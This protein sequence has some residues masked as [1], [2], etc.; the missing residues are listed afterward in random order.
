MTLEWTS[1]DVPLGAGLDT[2]TNEKLL[3]PP[4]CADLVNAVFPATGISG[5]ETRKGYDR[6]RTET[7]LTGIDALATLENELLVV[8]N[9]K[10]YS[11]SELENNIDLVE[12]GDLLAVAVDEETL[13]TQAVNQTLGQII[14]HGGLQVHAWY[15]SGTST[16]QYTVADAVTGTRIVSDSSIANSNYP[17][18]A[19]TESSIL[20]IYY[21]S[22]ATSLRCTVIP[23]YAPTSTSDVELAS[24][25]HSD[26]L[27]DCTETDSSLQTVYIVYKD[28][29]NPGLTALLVDG[30]GSVD[31]SSLI[32][33][34]SYDVTCLAVST[35]AT[36]FTVMAATATSVDS[37]Y[38][39]TYPSSLRTAAWPTTP[40]S[41]SNVINLAYAAEN[42]DTIADGDEKHYVWFEFAGSSAQFNYVQLSIGN[43]IEDLDLASPN[44]TFRQC[45]LAS[46]AFLDGNTPYVHFSFDTTLQRQYFLVNS[47]GEVHA[48]SCVGIGAGN[49]TPHLPRVID[50]TWAPV[51]R[52]HLDIDV[53]PDVT[54]TIADVYAQYG[55]KKVSYD[56]TYRP[57]SI[58]YGRAAYIQSGVLWEYD[59]AQLVE[60]GFHVYPEGITATDGAGGSLTL[61]ASYSYRVY[62]EWINARGE[63]QRSTTATILT[64]A[65]TGANQRITLTIP[66]LT[67]SLKGTDVSIVVY[68]SESDP[69]LVGGAPMYRVSSPDPTA[70]GSNGYVAND[71]TTDTVTFVDDLADTDLVKKELDYLNSGEVDNLQPLPSI[72]IGEAKNRV[73]TANENRAYYSKQNARG[74]DQLEFHDTLW[75]DVP[76]EDG[77]ITAF[78]ALNFHVVMF[79][80]NSCYAVSGEGKNNLG[81]GFFNLPQVVSLD[82]GCIEPRSIVNIPEGILFKSNKG[83]WRLGH[84][85]DMVYVGANVEAYNDQSI[86]SATVIPEENHVV[87]LTSSGS[88]LV[89]NYLVNA[90]SRWTNHTGNSAV[91]WNGSYTYSRTDG[92]IYRQ[93]SNYSD[94]GVHYAMKFITAPIGIKGV[95]GK[96]RIKHI[97]LLGEYFSPHTLRVGLK[98]NHHPGVSDFGTWDPADAISVSTYGSGAYGAGAYG[99]D[100]SPVYQA[101]FNM[102]RQKCQTVQFVI[103]STNSGGAGRAM[104]IQ[105]IQ[106][107][108][109]AKT[110]TGELS[111]DRGFSATG[112]STD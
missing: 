91:I 47:T 21:N 5:Y 38:S 9:D 2:K 101:R 66:T 45:S 62:Y 37:Y 108:V 4:A 77:D 12:K 106:I 68:R 55:L 70:T 40:H 79:K 10:L 69:N 82:V 3:K 44:S 8:G 86:T 71:P 78:G 100:G 98:F 103:D 23:I 35:T 93:G 84:N 112:G 64:D 54:E 61:L 104:S 97:R 85:L 102:P 14:T 75:V 87:F 6:I 99:G 31:D 94:D 42:D 25:M 107:E 73:W 95:Q 83:I 17:K 7:S 34:G 58:E 13:D 76:E 105:A 49:I 110:G 65:T 80:E 1:L 32:R 43:G 90:W 39:A 27:F 22:S 51:F 57:Q 26:G 59:G 52:E 18:L 74:R 111:V 48:K 89:Y 16:V 46:C 19:K 11:V 28:D 30:A 67:H 29:S 15:D 63:R 20:V 92:R 96:Q 41:V 53:D 36:S 88:V 24:D 56:L 81:A 50:W 33:G 109:G 60:Q 72:V